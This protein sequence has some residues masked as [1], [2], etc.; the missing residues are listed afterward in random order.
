MYVLYMR[1]VY[2]VGRALLETARLFMLD[3]DQ[4]RIQHL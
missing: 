1:F 3:V 4:K 2:I